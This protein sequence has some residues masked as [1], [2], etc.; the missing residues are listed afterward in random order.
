VTDPLASE[1]VFDG[2]SQKF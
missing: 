1:I 2:T